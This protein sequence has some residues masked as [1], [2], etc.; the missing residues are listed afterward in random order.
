MKTLTKTM[1]LFLICSFAALALAGC[2]AVN[3][4]TA[5]NILVPS[6]GYNKQ[7]FSYGNN[8]RQ[9]MDVY[10]P[11]ASVQKIPVVF[12][13][14]GAWRS[15]D[16]KNF[17]FVAQAL[18]SL[19]HPV[20]VPDYRRFPEVQFPDFIDDVA[21]AISFVD[22]QKKLGLAKPFTEY[23]LMGHS[24][25][26]HTAAL[27]AAD[28]SYLRKRGVKAQLKGLIGMA[29]PYDLPMND[30]EVFPVFNTSTPEK[31][32]VTTNVRRGMPPTLLLHGL[33]DARVEPFHTERFRDVLKQ[34]GND[35]TTR[36]Y[37]GVNHTKI[38]GSLAVPLRFLNNSFEDIKGF[39]AR[40]N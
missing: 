13:Y 34:N 6:G 38:I 35:V 36:L 22:R 32:K 9:S 5:I 39:L 23:I 24:A 28:T 7:Q 27:L 14:G 10:T 29:G 31:T 21:D 33:A 15:G 12:V 30:P 2:A 3:P 40:Y 16:K 1:T 20:I 25:G 37:P 11:K 18:T 19:G 17:I 4:T 26:A 8:R